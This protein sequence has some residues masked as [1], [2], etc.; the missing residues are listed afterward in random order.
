MAPHRPQ[1]GWTIPAVIQEAVIVLGAT[2]VFGIF[3]NLVDKI[4]VGLVA[5]HFGLLP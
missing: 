4:V 3:L 1:K 2:C 5:R